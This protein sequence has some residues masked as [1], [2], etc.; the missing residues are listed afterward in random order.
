M[1]KPSTNG[2]VG[3]FLDAL[4]DTVPD[5]IARAKQEGLRIRTESLRRSVARRTGRLAESFV[6]AGDAVVSDAPYVGFVD[7]RSG[8]VEQA[9]TRSSRDVE[10]AVRRETEAALER[11]RQE[12]GE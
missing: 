4:L 9:I 8:F 2:A 5:A 3:R 1:I 10:D 11:A 6:V 7:R 12:A